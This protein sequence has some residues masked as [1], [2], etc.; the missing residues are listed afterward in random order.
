[1]KN[2]LITTCVLLL[3]L[4]IANAQN[5][6]LPS[7]EIKTLEGEVITT[8]DID[9]NNNPIII[10]FWNLA[11]K[12]CKLEL[13]NIA[14]VYD[15]WQEETGVKLIAMST[16]NRRTLHKV[17]PYVESEG[18]EYEVYLDSNQELKRAMA[19]Q[20]MPHTFLLNGKKEIVWQHTGY[21][22]GDED[23]LYEEVKKL[24]K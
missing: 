3:G 2:I 22:P 9:N 16:D 18:W 11:C 1:M 15:E 24:S 5:R 4:E 19:V 6:T 20:M 14:E 13:S 12:P 21:L 23:K 8:Q 7:V 10:S 17:A